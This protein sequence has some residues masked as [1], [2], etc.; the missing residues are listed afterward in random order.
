MTEV[1]RATR[2]VRLYVGGDLDLVDEY[3]RLQE[4]AAD[5]TSLAGA[6]TARLDEVRALLAADEMPFRFQALGRR[7]LR[8][9]LDDNPPRKDKPRDQVIGFNEDAA[10]AALIRKCLLD[11]DL[12]EAALTELLDEDLTDGQYEKLSD[13]VWVLNRRTVDVPFSST[14][15]TSPRNSAGG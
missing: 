7:S 8:K 12:P 13:A 9:L 14:A 3:N 10:T 5:P 15:S 11:P 2:T 1:K 6:D 4:E